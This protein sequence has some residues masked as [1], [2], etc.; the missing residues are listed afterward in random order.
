MNISRYLDSKKKLI[1]RHLLKYLVRR[2]QRQGE[3][4]LPSGN[5][6][7]KTLAKSMKYS[8]IARCKRI[9]PILA[10]SACSAVGGKGK[11][12]IPTACAIELIHTFTLIHDDLPAMDNDD[13]RRGKLSNHKVFGEDI[14]ILS[15]DALQALAYRI[16]AEKTDKKVKRDI[17]VKVVSEISRALVSVVSGQ[18]VDIKLEGKKYTRKDLEF[19]HSNKTASLI[20]AS[21]LCGGLIGGASKNQLK[22]LAK[23]GENLGLAFQIIDDILDVT[24]TRKK[25]GKTPRKDVRQKKATYPKLIGLDQSKHLA[26]VKL[27]ASINSLQGLGK[28]F[29][30]LRSIA[31]YLGKR[32]S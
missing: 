6:Y 11:Y 26:G 27:K 16:I 32:K 24:S 13:W 20:K 18:V 4:G 28:S 14:A 5:K 2:S 30:I 31:S 7:T 12:V 10:L 3:A 23:Y 1:D 19:V 15:G 17:L 21:I 8:T 9:R 29:N 22:K 25:L